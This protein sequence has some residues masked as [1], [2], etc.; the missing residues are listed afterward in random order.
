MKRSLH[1]GLFIQPF[2]FVLAY[3]EKLETE[4]RSRNRHCLPFC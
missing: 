3:V 2:S 1:S 4:S